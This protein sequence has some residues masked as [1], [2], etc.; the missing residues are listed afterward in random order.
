[1]ILLKK[2]DVTTWEQVEDLIEKKVGVNKE[3]WRAICNQR[4]SLGQFLLT[5]KEYFFENNTL[6]EYEIRN[7]KIDNVIKELSIEYSVQEEKN[8]VFI[9]QET[10]KILVNHIR[11]GL[12]GIE[13]DLVILCKEAIVNVI[14][15][16]NYLQG[17]RIDEKV[18]EECFKTPFGTPINIFN[19]YGD[20]FE[21]RDICR[22]DDF[23]IWSYEQIRKLEN[24]CKDDIDKRIFLHKRVNSS[25]VKYLINNFITYGSIDNIL[26][27]IKEICKVD[28]LFT[29]ISL[30][31][32]MAHIY[33]KIGLVRYYNNID[34]EFLESVFKDSAMEINRK[35]HFISL[36]LLTFYYFQSEEEKEKLYMEMQEWTEDYLNAIEKTELNILPQRVFSNRKDGR[37]RGLKGEKRNDI[38]YC[39][40]LLQER[41]IEYCKQK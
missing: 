23:T 10:R 41:I 3:K 29:R 7:E 18:L 4:M 30:S 38:R 1:M 22:N 26:G 12:K 21:Y 20:E 6:N 19:T 36:M 34:I 40:A 27:I 24:F 33:Y 5:I 13:N 37:I 15:N 17:K 9:N 31:G 2:I 14:F 32:Y 25:L 35:I 28:A 11:E 8:K 39:Y 16:I